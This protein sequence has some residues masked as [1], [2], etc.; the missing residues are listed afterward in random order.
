MANT[1]RFVEAFFSEPLTTYATGWRDQDGL[2]D[3]LDFIAPPTEVPR[4]F[5]YQTFPNAEA[6]LTETDD[7]RGIGADFKRVEYTSNKA[8]GTTLNKGLT[9]RVDL[10][11]V[12]QNTNWRERTIG[13]LQER[14]L[15]NE[16]RRAIT[17]LAAAATN[18]GLRACT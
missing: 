18:T 14:I 13:K 5:E 9:L 15:R 7:I 4:R 2:Q 12:D 1:S 10:D 3:L 16:V 6:F 8:T 17:L 11:N